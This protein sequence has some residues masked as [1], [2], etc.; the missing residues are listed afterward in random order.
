MVS[1][2]DASIPTKLCVSYVLYADDAQVCGNFTL[3][4]LNEG[5]AI[6]QRDAQAV[7]ILDNRKRTCA[8]R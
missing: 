1:P 7:F 4:D 5:I 6:M 8:Q 2:T 3:S